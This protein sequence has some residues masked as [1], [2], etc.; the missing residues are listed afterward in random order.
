MLLISF[1]MSV[2]YN[3]KKLKLI[4]LI[5]LFKI[6]I[7]IMHIIFQQNYNQLEPHLFNNNKEFKITSIEA[8]LLS[9]IAASKSLNCHDVF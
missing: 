4:A 5:S 2:R 6:F 9:F 8:S 3:E 7:L 1:H